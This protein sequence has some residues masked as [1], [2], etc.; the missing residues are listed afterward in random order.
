MADEKDKKEENG[1]KSS[2]LVLIIVG[3]LVVVILLIGGIVAFMLLSKDETATATTSADGT[4]QPV[5][6]KQLDDLSVGPIFP[7]DQFIVNLTS[8]G[9]K[10]FLKTKLELELNDADLL[11]ELEGKKPRIRDIIIR[12]L[13]SKTVEEISTPKGKDKL[14][15]ELITQLNSVLLDGQVVRL[16]FTEFVIQ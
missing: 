4:Q 6:R 13:S 3:I 2:S 9:G 16:Y 10:R 5:Q 7:V 11:T 12:V 8:D 1:K 14:K 15:Q